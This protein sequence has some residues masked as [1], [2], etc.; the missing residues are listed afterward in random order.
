MNVLVIVEHNNQSL[1]SSYFKTLTAAFELSNQITVLIAGYQCQNIIT[2][3][4]N[5]GFV[6]HIMLADDPAY[7]YFLAESFADL[8]ARIC[9][10]KRFTHVLMPATNFGKNILPRVA[11]LLDVAVIGDVVEIL[12]A[13]NFVRP[14]QAGSVLASVYSMDCIKLITICTAAFVAADICQANQADKGEISIESMHTVVINSRTCLIKQ[15]LQESTRPELTAARIIVAGGRALQNA[16]SFK[17]LARIADQLNAALG[18]SRPAIDAG[19]FTPDCQVGQTGKTVAPDLYIAVGISGAIHH[20]AGMS[21]SK[22]IAAINHDEHAPIFDVA[23]YGLV[24][25]LLTVLPLLEQELATSNISPARTEFA[26]TA[27]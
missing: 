7:Q 24:A 3:V 27:T 23:D 1:S 17:L 13:D 9:Q 2:A 22:V 6:Q 18:A 4:K 21:S 11:G 12:D 8:I 25:D 14:M 26:R 16:E 19:F 15:I 10:H 20:L 5:H